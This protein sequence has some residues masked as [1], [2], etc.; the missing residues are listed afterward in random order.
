MNRP[1]K[2]TYLLLYPCALS[3]FTTGCSNA[4]DEAEDAPTKQSESSGAKAEPLQIVEEIPREVYPGRE[5]AISITTLP[6]ATC[7]VHEQD[8]EST[9][10]TLKAFADDEGQ[11]VIH[12]TVDDAEKP[13]KVYLDCASADGKLLRHSLTVAARPNAKVRDEIRPRTTGLIRPSLD[14]DPMALSDLELRARH[15]PPRPDPIR[16][17]QNYAAWLQAVHKPVR[18]I[19]A[20]PI[21]LPDQFNSRPLRATRNGT[22]HGSANWAGFLGED[23]AVYHEA[24][25]SWTVPSVT[26]DGINDTSTLW[27]G[28]GGVYENGLT[29]DGTHHDVVHL[30][31]GNV[32]TYRCWI[33]YYPASE[34]VLPMT[35][36]PGDIFF[37]WAEL[38]DA[39]GNINSSGGYG[40]YE[41]MNYTRG[42]L[43]KGV[44]RAPS[45]SAVAAD[46]ATSTAEF[47]MEKNVPSSHLSRFGSITNYT[48][49]VG[50]AVK[51]GS[52]TTQTW[53][54][55]G[56]STF[57]LNGSSGNPL[58]ALAQGSNQVTFTWL[59]FN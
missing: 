50:G 57:T 32:S 27:V 40:F 7:L 15:Y 30:S 37:V 11:V 23:Y 45:G 8:V 6:S 31:S 42:T 41:V 25:S 53:S 38:S 29:Q 9:E 4:V 58:V 1:S 10:S 49:F 56:I 35:T 18:M 26:G 14:G 21:P 5:T 34:Q 54:T 46:P 3:I 51:D 44:L 28:L 20:A 24:F 19:T 55:P 2:L 52:S 47:I 43:W 13:G 48:I 39:S 22:V 16:S 17:A 36:A 12:M 59:R 33:E